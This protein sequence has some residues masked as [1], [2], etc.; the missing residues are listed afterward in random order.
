MSEL[1]ST[2]KPCFLIPVYNHEQAVGNVVK[3]LLP[4]RLPIILVDDGSNKVCADVLDRL[5]AEHRLVSLVRHHRNRGKGAA[6]VT[7]FHHADNMGCTHA[8]QLDADGQH[9]LSAVTA[10]LDAARNAPDTLICGYPVYDDSVPALRQHGRKLSNW[11]VAF[12]AR[13]NAF[14]DTMCG[15]RLYPLD[16][17]C[18]LLQ[19]QRMSRR[20]EFDCEILVR[21]SWA[22]MPVK[23]LPVN[24]T[25]PTDGVSHFRALRDNVL[26]SCMHA[27]LCCTMLLNHSALRTRQHHHV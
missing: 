6:C 26:I 24:V 8:F 7:G 14:A 25:Y 19:R 17:L 3:A 16:T 2:F 20:M 21:L 13:S 27:K 10:F 11:W 9:D 12:N 22:D 1:H 18:P 15:F 4:H 23:N 5:A